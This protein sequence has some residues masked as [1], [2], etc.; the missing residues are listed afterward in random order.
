MDALSSQSNLVLI[1]RVRS[2]RVFYRQPSINEETNS[3]RAHRLWYGERFDLKDE[4]TW[5]LPDAVV[6][7]LGGYKVIPKRKENDILWSKRLKR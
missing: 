7:R 1:T 5:H 3:G 2:N 4:I 6:F